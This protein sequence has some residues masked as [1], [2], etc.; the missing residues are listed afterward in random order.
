MLQQ[1]KQCLDR[2]ENRPLIWI[3]PEQFTLQAERNLI[4]KLSLPGMLNIEVLSFKRLA[5]KVLREV[6]GLTRIHINEQGKNMALRKIIDEGE[7]YLTIYKNAS[8][9]DGFIQMLGE[10][11]CELKQNNIFPFDLFERMKKFEQN[12]IFYKKIHDIAYIYEQLDQYL[13]GRYVDT[14][15]YMN[16]VIDRMEEAAF[17]KEAEIWI[18]G[19]HTFAPQ[20]YRMIEKLMLVS[21]GL[22]ISFPFDFSG[23]DKEGD[24]FRI[25]QTAYEI[26]RDIAMRYG[27]PSQTIELDWENQCLK[28]DPEL[29]H[30]Q[31]HLYAYPYQIYEEKVKN[32][33]I[34]EALNP[35]T[36]VEHVAIQ[37]ISLVRE[38]GYRWRD[39]AVVS[40][41]LDKYG[42]LIERAFDEYGIP[43]FMDQKRTVMHNPIVEFVLSSLEAVQKGYRYEEMFR[44]LK[45]GFGGIDTE[46][47][48]RLENYILRCGIQGQRWKE[49]FLSERDEEQE[50]LDELNESKNKL[51]EAFEQ[52][53]KGLKGKKTVE[54]MT[55]SLYEFLDKMQLQQQLENWIDSLREKGR[56]EYVYENAQIWNILMEM[57]DQLVEIL[58]DQKMALKEY[59]RILESGFLSLEVA[60]I[61][62]GM[63]QVLVGN[64]QRSKSQ[65]IKALFVLGVNDGILPS[66][67]KEE[68][69]LSDEDKMLLVEEG[70]ELSYDREREVCE[71]RFMIY[72]AF[73]KPSEY[74]WLSYA[75]ADGEGRAMRRSILIERLL[76]LFPKLNVRSDIAYPSEDE[77]QLI[78]VPRGT[79]KYLIEN[80]GRAVE[81]EPIEEIWWNVYGW[82]Y[83]RKEWD[84]KRKMVLEGLFHDNR[85]ESIRAADA[86]K[87]YSVP[88]RASISRMELFSRCPFAHFIQYGLGPKQRDVFQI[89]APDMGEIFHRCIELFAKRMEEE[90]ISW[91]DLKREQCERIFDQIVDEVAPEHKGG[92]LLS[93]YRYRYLMNRIKRIGR[94][95]VWTLTEHMQ[96]SGFKLLG[97]EIRFGLGQPYPPIKIVLPDGETVY[98]EGRI[99]RVDVLED[100]ENAYVKIIDYKSGNEDFCLA[101]TYYGLKIQLMVYLEAVLNY[102]SRRTKKTVKPAGIFYFKID[103]PMIKTEDAVIE[104]IEKEIRK[105]LKLKGLVLKDVRIV[106]YMDSEIKGHSE[107]LPVGLKKEGEFYSGSSVATDNEFSILLEH[108]RNLLQ[109]RIYEMLHGNI[110]IRPVKIEKRKAC[111]FCNYHSIC[112]FDTLLE[113]NRYR[114][115]KMLSDEE[116]MERIR[117]HSEGEGKR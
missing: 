78:S 74:L 30:I 66:A 80:L 1:V 45:T 88:I 63:D 104:K 57:L 31:K 50:W 69:I 79:F 8:R 56:Y 114:H 117:M 67:R 13:K 33:H 11:L 72:S 55:R 44:V 3:V 43:Y 7:E 34:F 38:R 36:E 105:K 6:G 58:G 76:R 10:F 89:Y 60:I 95:S 14:E 107:I 12:N 92:V 99:D 18:D 21:K 61:P 52:L 59:I 100:G 23:K 64:I 47:C 39:I 70:L 73:S 46:E 93:T 91:N 106:R 20:L 26:I 71:E 62:T 85:V 101:D 17:L 108:V 28:N 90:N 113:G 116:V 48:E 15:D 68:G 87:I 49:P 22:H 4:E 37:I 41:D 110:A 112:Q 109:D 53:E 42:S 84:T 96:R 27:V 24:L 82:Y 40:N 51:M 81:G 115:L 9:L 29:R 97:N 94:R 19:F 32:V 16:L 54:E 102:Q 65:D 86:K 75:V 5:Y 111:D 25:P 77:K 98:L 35:Y 83:N 103:D 2:G